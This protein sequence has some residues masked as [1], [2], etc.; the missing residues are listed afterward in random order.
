MSK[1]TRLREEIVTV[2]RSLHMRGLSPGS[3]G[4]I[5]ARL[6]DGWLL[7][8]TNACLGE[9]DPG[10]IAKLDWEGNHL[11]GKPASKEAFLHHA[12]YAGRE[13]SGAIVHLHC[14]HSAAV[15]CLDCLDPASALP[16]LTPYFVM[17]VGRLPLVPY[18][19]P[20]DP[21]LG[22]AISGLVGKHSAVLLA[23]HG[24]LVS[25]KT[26]EAAGYA[27]E[28]L[29]ETAKLFLLLRQQPV[30]LLDEEQ[31]EELRQTFGAQW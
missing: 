29:E 13:D 31:I 12:V 17:R 24:P 28:E 14:T 30:R 2:G 10:D 22:E 18:H 11:A 25:G 19:R 26:L 5:S 1:E 27:I 6:D 16:P 9:L 15:S 7:T 20:G 23:N 8:P 21:R 3:S 4:N